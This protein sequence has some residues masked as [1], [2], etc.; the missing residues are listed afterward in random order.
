MSAAT[1]KKTSRK[2]ATRKKAPA[3]KKAPRKT[4]SRGPLKVALASTQSVAEVPALHAALAA[5]TP[6]KAVEIDAG[7]LETVDTATL[8]VLAAFARRNAK[9]TW[10]GELDVLRK[11]ASACGLEQALALPEAAPAEDEEDDLCPVF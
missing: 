1:K 9:L 10:S 5:S 8:Q 6:A 11:A 4:A 3:R 7:A 2:T